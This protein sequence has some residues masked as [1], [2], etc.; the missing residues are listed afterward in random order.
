MPPVTHHRRHYVTVVVEGKQVEGWESYRIESNMITPADNFTMRRPFDAKAWNLLERDARV[1]VTVDATVIVD[2][3]IDRRRKG[4]SEDS[5]EIIGRDRAGRLVQ[6]SAESINYEGLLLQEAISRLVEE[7]FGE[8]SLS[9]ARNRSL[10]RGK[11][12]RVA[13]GA[14]PVVINIRVPRSGRVH[15]GMTRWAIIEEICSKA[16]YLVTSSADGREIIVFKPNYKQAPQFLIAHPRTGSRTKSTCLDL[17]IDEDNQDR[18]SLITVAGAGGS[19]EDDVNY[20]SNVSSRKGRWRDGPGIDGIGRDFKY[21]KRLYMP[22]RDFESNNDAQRVA[23]LEA[24][25]RNFRRTTVTARMPYHGQFLSADACTIFAPNTIARVIDED[26]EPTL[27][28]PHLIY[29][30]AFNGD[31]DSGETTDLELVPS[32]TEIVL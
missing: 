4:T 6:E 18:Y 32:G 31:R 7:W 5:L 26:F 25:R 21:P 29:S 28:A 17:T 2:G 16:G 24:A 3:F 23:E 11:G 12:R 20:G 14:E 9:D 10:R 13:A 19:D 22:E 1:R 27:D 15:P 8:V 30:C